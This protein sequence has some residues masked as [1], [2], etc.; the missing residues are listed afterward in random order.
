MAL[1]AALLPSIG[2]GARADEPPAGAGAR[3]AAPPPVAP[4]PRGGLD[5]DEPPPRPTPPAVDRA[6]GDP[7]L[8]DDADPTAPAVPD[9]RR[10]IQG[11]HPF[12]PEQ[13]MNLDT[14]DVVGR[15]KVYEGDDGKSQVYVFA[16]NP[17]LYGGTTR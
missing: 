14:D 2:P 17:H 4:A 6:L 12:G 8:A 5:V 9:P 15:M 10:P 13:R 1:A 16:G 3:P 7:T 11:L